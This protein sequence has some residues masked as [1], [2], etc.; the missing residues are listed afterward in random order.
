MADMVISKINSKK[1]SKKKPKFWKATEDYRTLEKMYG[2][3]YLTSSEISL[4]KKAFYDYKK[5]I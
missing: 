4:L 2:R 1:N 5:A 3:E